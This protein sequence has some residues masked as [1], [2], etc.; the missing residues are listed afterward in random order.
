MVRPERCGVRRL[1]R[2]PEAAGL[3]HSGLETVGHESGGVLALYSACG[4][5]M[6]VVISA[7]GGWGCTS[8]RTLSWLAMDSVAMLRVR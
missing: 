4:R 5:P 3:D 7:V 2:T 8:L 1:L 6:A